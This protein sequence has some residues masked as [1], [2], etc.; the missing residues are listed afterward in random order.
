MS[1]VEYIT[2]FSLWCLM[3]A[4]LL[5]GCDIRNI[6][7]E[8]MN[9]LTNTDA[10]A[11][12]QDPLGIQGHKI[13]SNGILEVWAGPLKDH[14][15]AVILLNK[16]TSIATISVS[17]DELGF[18]DDNLFSVYD[19]WQHKNLGNFSGKFSAEV[20][21]HGVMFGKFT[22]MDDSLE[23]TSRLTRHIAL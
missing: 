15:M 6:S 7:P 14:S 5:I 23:K 8:T 19:I 16:G 21:A 9:I 18:E 2:H 11:I 4:P 12:N 10:I 22:R 17:S 3:K 13:R 1:N 20:K